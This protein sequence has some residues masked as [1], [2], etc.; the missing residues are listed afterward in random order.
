MK[1]TLNPRNLADLAHTL[2]CNPESLGELDTVEKHRQFVT[3]MARVIADHCGGAVPVEAY[4]SDRG[5]SVDVVADD[6]LPDNG[7]VWGAM[8]GQ[9][10]PGIELRDLSISTTMTGSWVPRAGIM[11]THRPTGA[12]AQSSEQRSDFK[13]RQAAIDQL[14]ANPVVIAYAALGTKQVTP[15]YPMTIVSVLECA[16]PYVEGAYECAFPDEGKNQQVLSDIN[17]LIQRL[18]G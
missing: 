2:L 14:L 4:V 18:K 11:V 3:A 16:R 13:N 12:W 5:C 9:A 6:S 15:L 8:S 1:I 10:A 7:G 17:D